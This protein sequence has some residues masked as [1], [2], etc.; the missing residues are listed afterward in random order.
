MFKE[1]YTEK[2]TLDFHVNQ[3]F[4]SRENKGESISEMIQKIKSLG[5]KFR[6]AAFLNC[7][8]EEKAGIFI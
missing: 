3:L 6:D 7:N 8:E 4:K 5:F 1:Y 2:W